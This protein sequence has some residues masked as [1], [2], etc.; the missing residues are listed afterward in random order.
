MKKAFV[1]AVFV[2]FSL[3]NLG[4]APA[5][6]WSD[7]TSGAIYYNGGNVGIGT[8]TPGIKL[9]VYSEGGSGAIIQ[10]SYTLGGVD[11]WFEPAYPTLSVLRKA[12]NK[13]AT[14]ALGN[15]DKVFYLYGSQA[16]FK[17]Y[18]PSKAMALHINAEDGNVGIR[19]ATPQSELAVNGTITAKE[20]I[21]TT[22][23]W[24]DY[25]LKDDY[26]LMPLNE[27]EQNIKKNGHLP[28]IPSAEDV[29]KKGVSLGEM[30][31]K[32]LQKIEELTLHVIEQS[33]E[34][35]QLKDEN[36]ML[37]KQVATVRDSL[38]SEK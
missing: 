26:K 24:A 34:L 22:A 1:F 19:T 32:L 33:K 16:S 17:L 6:D 38:Q 14:I 27:L 3:S 4:T 37:K 5:A 23:G 29:K 35:R 21:V 28:D 12:T 25:V 10:Q 8:T 2:L 13:G 31:A 9:H 20:V 11:N 15:S 30:Q 7:G 18:S 36:E